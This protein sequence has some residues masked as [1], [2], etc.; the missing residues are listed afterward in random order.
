MALFA[1]VALSLLPAG[2]LQVHGSSHYEAPLTSGIYRPYDISD[3]YSFRCPDNTNSICFVV[4]V[5]P[6]LQ[7]PAGGP[8]FY[9]FSDD[10]L[11]DIKIDN[12][13]DAVEDVTFRFDFSRSY[14]INNTFLY[15]VGPI[16]SLND[17]D[18]NFHQ[19]YNL[20]MIKNG[21]TTRILTGAPVPPHN[22]GDNHNG[23]VSTQNYGALSS[24]AIQSANFNG[25]IG[26]AFAGQRDDPFFVDLGATFDLLQERPPFFNANTGRDGVAG[27]NVNVLALQVPATVLTN[28]GAVPNANSGNHIIGVWATTSIPRLI[29]SNQN[30][31]ALPVKTQY[32]QVSRLGQPLV[33]E[34]VIPIQTNLNGTLIGVKDAFNSL[35]PKDDLATFSAVFPTP[36]N[37]PV[38]DPEVG[39]LLAGLYNINVP[40]Q[41]SRNYNSSVSANVNVNGTVYCQNLTNNSGRSDLLTIFLTGIPGINQPAS[42][43]PSEMLRLNMTTPV[44]SA[45]PIDATTH[46][47]RCRAGLLGG[48]GFGDLEGY[49]N[50]RR[51]FDDVTDISLQAVAGAAYNV[52]LGGGVASCITPDPLAGQLGDAVPQ[53]DRPFMDTFPYVALPFDG[54]NSTPGEMITSVVRTFALEYPVLS[55]V[56]QLPSAMSKVSDLLS[57]VGARG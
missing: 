8:N 6:L 11:Y 21:V 30:A 41:P 20:D 16:T 45:C 37:H 55:V 9:P 25:A 56:D 57:Q 52:I 18:L 10:A 19:T 47:D 3:V 2:A 39:K 43:A 44:S 26:K 17:S 36:V 23:L 40:P 24:A 33:N 27:Y 53:N 22:I 49:P 46:S 15:N 51:L 7:Q 12:N 14:A 5:A 28:N 38:L 13:G 1:A 35:E 42:V 34:V 31:S 32:R 50:G 4:D 48:L 54:Y 29:V